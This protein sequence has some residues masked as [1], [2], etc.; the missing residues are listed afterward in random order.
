M[1]VTISDTVHASDLVPAP[2]TRQP[3]VR[4]RGSR[5]MFDPAIVRRAALDAVIKLD[6]RVQARNPVMFVVLVGS[7]WTTVLFVRDLPSATRADNVFVGLVAA[8]LWF[9]VLF[10]KFAEA[11]AE[12]R[13][14][15]QADTLR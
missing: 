14:K 6:P 3:K 9:T 13:G 11:M 2:E 10:A 1:P 4:G 12:G 8:F 5:S 15:A 7:A